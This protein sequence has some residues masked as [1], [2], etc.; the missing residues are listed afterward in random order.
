MLLAAALL[1]EASALDPH[2]PMP[3]TSAE[4]SERARVL[5]QGAGPTLVL[6]SPDGR[7]GPA[8]GILLDQRHHGRPLAQGWLLPKDFLAPAAWRDTAA[9]TPLEGLIG[10]GQAGPRRPPAPGVGPALASMGIRSVYL[11]TALASDALT[12]CVEETLGRR[13]RAAGPYRVFDLGD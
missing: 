12:L 2:L 9:A 10:C 8:A 1:F 13:S 7:P 3:A 5:A 4:P 6:P 11:D